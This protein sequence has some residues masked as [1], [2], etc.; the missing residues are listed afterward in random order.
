MR[1]VRGYVL[2]RLERQEVVI[3]VGSFIRK[4]GWWQGGDPCLWAEVDRDQTELEARKLIIVGTRSTLPDVPK[5]Y[6]GTVHSETDTWHV[7]EQI[8]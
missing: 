6:I 4:V 3:P 8:L 1:E 7:Y 5:V 2:S